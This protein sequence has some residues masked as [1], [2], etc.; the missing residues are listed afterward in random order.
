V[1]TKHVTTMSQ[2]SKAGE[3]LARSHPR[4]MA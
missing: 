4:N 1:Q 2:L 3:L